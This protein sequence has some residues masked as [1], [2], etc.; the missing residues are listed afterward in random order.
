[1]LNLMFSKKS[2]LNLV[3]FILHFSPLVSLNYLSPNIFYC[4]KFFL[5]LH[6]VFYFF[7]IT[8]GKLSFLFPKGFSFLFSE[9]GIIINFL[10]G[11]SIFCL[12]TKEIKVIEH[13]IHLFKFIKFSGF[14]YFQSCTL[15]SLIDFRI[16][17]HFFFI[18]EE[19]THSNHS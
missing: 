14:Q 17:S 8:E 11:H 4:H 10:F 9:N 13:K 6:V 15:I 7:P 19:K 12:T 2:F 18:P 5:D 3:F 16:L 1:M